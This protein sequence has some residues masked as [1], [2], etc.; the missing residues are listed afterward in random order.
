LAA[1]RGQGPSPAIYEPS[2]DAAVNP[3]GSMAIERIHKI[4]GAFVPGTQ[5]FGDYP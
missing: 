3:A 2:A 1:R 4:A 5:N